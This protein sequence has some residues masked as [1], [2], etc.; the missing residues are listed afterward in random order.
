MTDS[1][2]LL[3]E[4][5]SDAFK[6]LYVCKA[7]LRLSNPKVAQ[8]EEE[9]AQKAVNLIIQSPTQPLP[10][11]IY[12]TTSLTPQQ[13]KEL[14]NLFAQFKTVD[15]TVESVGSG[16]STSYGQWRGLCLGEQVQ[17]GC[18]SSASHEIISY[19]DF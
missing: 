7:K 2:A 16:S 15:N 12:Q 14:T 6:L 10:Q 4:L 13:T 5:R 17:S 1:S 18:P 11:Q 9:N 8:Q 19:G 3:S